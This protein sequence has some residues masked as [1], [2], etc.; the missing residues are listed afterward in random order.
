MTIASTHDTIP[1]RARLVS[2]GALPFRVRSSLAA[3]VIIALAVYVGL[4][5]GGAVVLRDPD[6]F[7]HINI[8]QWMLQHGTVPRVDFYSYTMA[9][10]PWIDT[11]WLSDVLYALAYNAGGWRAVVLVA[12][13][14]GAAVIGVAS[15]YLQQHLRFSIALLCAAAMAWGTFHHFSARPHLF[16]YL[17]LVVWLIALL[18]AFDRDK[19]TLPRLYL[20]AALMVLWAN[21]HGSFTL[22]LLLLYIFAGCCLWRGWAER[23]LA[24]CRRILANVALVSLCTLATPYVALPFTMTSTLLGNSLISS[25]IR[26]WLPPDFQAHR[27]WLIYFLAIVMVMPVLGVRLRGPRLLVLLALGILA[28]SYSRGMFT[29]LLL[30]P[31]VIA[32]PVAK[33]APYFARQEPMDRDAPQTDPVVGLLARRWR[34]VLAACLAIFC[35]A[36]I[37]AGWR[38][39]APDES[40][41]PVAAI[42]HVR[43]AGITG[44]VFNEY[45]FGGFLIAEGIP[46]IID[47]RAEL[48]VKSDLFRDYF[49]AKDCRDLGRALA[50]LDE[51]KIS[52][53]ILASDAP[54]AKALAREPQWERVF[55]DKTAVVFVRRNA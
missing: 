46:T 7:W 12:D 41:S 6:T 18:N 31:L 38:H 42:D 32:V 53:V 15:Y 1:T 33:A 50:M 48:F 17:V 27:D 13:L 43:K 54:F 14:T 10:K 52:W 45:N 49:A 55:A 20:T 37:V 3:S 35:A 2:N 21:L 9:G 23:D 28:L 16:A 19:P 51:Y 34:S 29:F 30:A 40:I 36:Q 47:G 44:N 11:A 22:G 26:E 8:G 5:I 24:E 4:F 39:V 25:H